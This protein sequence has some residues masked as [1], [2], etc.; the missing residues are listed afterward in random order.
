[1]ATSNSAQ[2]EEVDVPDFEFKKMLVDNGDF[3]LLLQKNFIDTWTELEYQYIKQIYS[4]CTISHSK[5]EFIST[6]LS[7]TPSF[8][9]RVQLVTGL[10]RKW[11]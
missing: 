10:N 7:A 11:L 3:V 2:V 9:V 4:H 5:T 8:L 6:A 1:M